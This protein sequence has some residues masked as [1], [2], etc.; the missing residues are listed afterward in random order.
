MPYE[1]DWETTAQV[2]TSLTLWLAILVFIWQFWVNCQQRKYDKSLLHLEEAT[3]A[4]EK[5]IS[6]LSDGNSDRVTWNTAARL[7][8]KADDIVSR[9]QIEELRY[10]FD[11]RKEGYRKDLSII[12]G[13]RNTEIT[14]SFFYGAVDRSIPVD[15]A[16][17]TSVLDQEYGG[18]ESNPDR[19]INEKA[20]FSIWSAVQFPADYKD[21]I[22]K[23]SIDEKFCR[24]INNIMYPGLAEYLKHRREFVV[25]DGVVVSREADVPNEMGG[26]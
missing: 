19:G 14:G 24:N 1:I 17:I 26:A 5:A 2:A 20:L 12:L 6:M 22:D 9:I 21:P 16:A 18:W 3:K 4:Y 15:K 23:E 25:K 11:A 8:S 13:Y 7:I 10:I